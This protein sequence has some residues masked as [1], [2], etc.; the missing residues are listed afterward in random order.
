MG[1]FGSFEGWRASSSSVVS[2][3]VTAPTRSATSSSVRLTAF[4]ATGSPS[5]PRPFGTSPASLTIFVSPPGLA[6][7]PFSNS[8]TPLV[9]SALTS[10]SVIGTIFCF[11]VISSRCTLNARMA[12]RSRARRRCALTSKNARQQATA[13]Y[14]AA[15]STSYGSA[16]ASTALSPIH[17]PK[18]P[19]TTA[20]SSI[21]SVSLATHATRPSCHA[22]MLLH[23]LLS[24]SSRW[25]F[26]SAPRY[27]ASASPG[28]SPASRRLAIS[29][30]AS[31][32]RFQRGTM[33]SASRKAT[34]AANIAPW[35]R[36]AM[37]G[38]I[39][40]SA[41]IP[42]SAPTTTAMEPFTPPVATRRLMRSRVPRSRESSGPFGFSGSP[43]SVGGPPLMDRIR[44]SF[45]VFGSKGFLWPPGSG[46]SPSSEALGITAN[47]P[48]R[49][50]DL[51]SGAADERA[52]TPEATG[53]GSSTHRALIASATAVL[54][55]SFNPALGG[56]PDER[57]RIMT[58]TWRGLLSSVRGGDLDLI[59]AC[60][61]Y[62]SV[63]CEL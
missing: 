41:L 1:G 29:S 9:I 21:S 20:L 60:G 42:T 39:C 45:V 43:P 28:L 4:S 16:P 24:A 34:G 13:A 2:D 48:N 46:A 55:S 7:S 35:D 47:R 10:S 37:S 33:T 59:C 15:P 51:L 27:R 58:R 11:P 8:A 63:L 6:F 56:A 36:D 49:R 30:S 53:R 14:M 38:W 57:P 54:M 61:L 12:F 19:I 23:G 52:L 17:A 25:Y 26:A 50:R 44:S 22:G 18:N 32:E 31:S 40:A 5:P 62:Y 3:S